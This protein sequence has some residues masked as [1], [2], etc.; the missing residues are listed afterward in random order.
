MIETLYLDGK[1]VLE[2]K[3]DPNAFQSANNPA[4]PDCSRHMTQIAN[5][6]DAAKGKARLHIDG[7][8]GRRA[9]RLITEIY[10]SSS[11]QA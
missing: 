9:I 10:K 8:E 7:R 1:V 2:S 3:P 5:L 6:M 4:I 11:E